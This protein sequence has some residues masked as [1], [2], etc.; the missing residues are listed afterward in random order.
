MAMS[1]RDPIVPEFC[2]KSINTK[3]TTPTSQIQTRKGFSHCVDVLCF[4]WRSVFL[5]PLSIWSPSSLCTIH[6]LFTSADPAAI[7][8]L[9]WQLPTLK[10]SLRSLCK[11][12]F[13]QFYK[14]WLA[15][16]QFCQVERPQLIWKTSAKYAHISPHCSRIQ[17]DQKKKKNYSISWHVEIFVLVPS[18][19]IFPFH[20]FLLSQTCG[21]TKKSWMSFTLKKLDWN[22]KESRSLKPVWSPEPSP[23]TAICKSGFAG[24]VLEHICSYSPREKYHNGHPYGEFYQKTPLSHWTAVFLQCDESS[25]LLM[26]RW[27]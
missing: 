5:S 12:P 16:V 17:S 3:H 20:L 24:S 27:A 8:S 14:Y 6:P 19:S 25:S 2:S 26:P 10:L 21:V 4:A 22:G 9:S 1:G 15:N 23:T 7:D 18:F 11:P 13:L